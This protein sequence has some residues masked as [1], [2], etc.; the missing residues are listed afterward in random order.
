MALPDDA[1]IGCVTLTVSN[2]ERSLGFYRDILGFDAMVRDGVGAVLSADGATPLVELIERTDA[3]ARPRRCTGLFHIAILVP[4]RAALGCS[5]RRLSD[6]KWPLTGVA[7]H[8]VSEA[9]YLD[10]PDG[11][12]VSLYWAGEKRTKSGRSARR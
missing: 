4:S 2:L 1:R 5:L 3:I 6:T 10:D 11:Y 9:L 12:E 7:D 8:L